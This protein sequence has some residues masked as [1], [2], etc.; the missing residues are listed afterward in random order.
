MTWTEPAL[1]FDVVL[2]RV[3]ENIEAELTNENLEPAE[4]CRLRWGAALIRSL[5]A[6]SRIT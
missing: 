3:R 2:S 6:P 1:S 5:L 4:E